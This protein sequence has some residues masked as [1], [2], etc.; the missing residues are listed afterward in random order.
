MLFGNGTNS[1]TNV[2]T[3]RDSHQHTWT[4]YYACMVE[5]WC[6]QLFRCMKQRSTHTYPSWSGGWI[7]CV[8]WVLDI[9]TYSCIII[10]HTH[11]IVDLIKELIKLIAF[12][13]NGI[14]N[15]MARTR[16]R[17]RECGWLSADWV[18]ENNGQ[19][20]Y[21]MLRYVQCAR[22]Y[23]KSVY[24]SRRANVNQNVQMERFIFIFAHDVFCRSCLFTPPATPHHNTHWNVENSKVIFGYSGWL[25]IYGIP[26]KMICWI[27]VNGSEFNLFLLHFAWWS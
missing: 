2:L 9:Q 11:T 4:V 27:D 1:C 21:A 19:P 10:S 15:G 7:V 12:H 20:I 22:R 23:Q 13:S 26:K 14:R 8:C 5:S 3:T 24:A 17:E 25:F 18:T 16:E 6:W